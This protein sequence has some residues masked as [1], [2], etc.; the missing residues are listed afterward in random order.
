MRRSSSCGILA[1]ALVFFFFSLEAPVFASALDWVGPER[2]AEPDPPTVDLEILEAP[3]PAPAFRQ[4]A[5]A[6][7]WTFHK[8]SD[9]QHPDG[10]EQQFLWLTNRARSDPAREGIWLA[11]ME[12]PQVAAARDY[13]KVSG[14][15]LQSEFAGYPAKPPAAFDARLY[16]AAKAHA[17]Y[18]IGIDGQNHN[19]QIAR[20]S[21]AGFAYNQAAGIVFSYSHH[22]I[23]GYAGF[24]IDWGAGTGGTQDPPGHRYAIMSLGA[25]YTNV[26]IAVVPETNPATQVGPQVIA[27]NFCHAVAGA[28]DHFNR[29]IVGT[30]WEDANSNG[31]HDP[32]EGL[33]GVTVMPD[34]GLYFAVTGDA[35]GYAIPILVADSYQL[36]FSGGDL[37]AVVTRTATVGSASVL[38]DL[39]YDGA[40]SSSPPVDSGESTGAGS[41]AGGGSGG[42][43]SGGCLIGAAAGRHEGLRESGVFIM[44]ACWLAGAAAISKKRRRWPVRK[45]EAPP[46]RSWQ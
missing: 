44:A 9:G 30:V 35:G 46:A 16:L 43:G 41:T 12:D 29:F 8:T 21:G 2:A 25:D 42:G 24:N 40:S 14:P 36:V 18:L 10:N 7:E 11:T 31:Q 19:N 1:A 5:A 32:G 3:G 15:I 6:I 22:T 17:D 39:E 27:G 34:K 23:H 45:R 13:F 20:I 38:L 4:A 28:A 26:G 33:A 37:G